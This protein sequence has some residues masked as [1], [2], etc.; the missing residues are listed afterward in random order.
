M[1]HRWLLTS[2]IRLPLQQAPQ[3]LHR[4]MITIAIQLD[5]KKVYKTTLDS[6]GNLLQSKVT[7][8]TNDNI[9]VSIGTMT[10]MDDSTLGVLKD[11]TLEQKAAFARRDKQDALEHARNVKAVRAFFRKDE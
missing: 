2:V 11:L 6:K 3:A 1:V 10:V 4:S 8:T 7:S 5:V 9:T